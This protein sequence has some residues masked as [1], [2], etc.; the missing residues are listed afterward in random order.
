MKTLL[1]W[2]GILVLVASVGCGS[3]DD[4]GVIRVW[5]H[6]GQE[7]EN[8]AMREIV[9][10]FNE[11]H[12]D[13]GIRVEI[14]F[15]PDYQYTERV[16]IAA[17]ARDLPDVF[18]LDGP[19]VAQFVAAGVLHPLTAYFSEDELDDFLDTII[20]QGT[21]DG[22]V[23]ALGAFDS[24]M[25]LYYNRDKLAAAGV[26]TPVGFEGWTWEEFV[27]ACKVLRDAG[28]DPVALHM[29]VTADEWY[30]YAFSPLIWSAGGAL[31][32]LDQNQV[33]GVLNSA[34]NADVL[35]HWQQLFDIGLAAR[36]P[37]NPDPFGVGETAM[38]WNGHWMARSHIE[39]HGESL[40]AMPLPNWGDFPVAPS[41]SWCW[42]IS[43]LSNQPELAARWLR[44]VI[45]PSTG[46]KPI[47][48]AGGAVP[49][50]RSAFEYFPEYQNLPFSLFRH[51][52][53]TAGRSRPQTP[54]YPNLTQQFAAALRDI[55]NGS[56]P[57]ERL[58][59]AAAA[60][61]RMMDR[62]RR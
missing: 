58:D 52:L 62:S 11:A 32:D 59:E 57:Q 10:A 1:A 20:Q 19:T 56:D 48:S 8:I 25:V 7:A 34:I 42:A 6:Q 45:D 12:A 33:E 30:T 27:A 54:H 43:A 36:N 17:A 18:G 37:I 46:I 31:I 41:G 47:V 26:E 60:V 3:V 50:R 38:D 24:A 61:Q 29:D 16:A 22:T 23:Y 49:A 13:E 2:L 28:V 51:L 9:A 40:G 44:W 14:N 55:A 53:E 39:A 4:T 15:F 5:S 35:G 21:V